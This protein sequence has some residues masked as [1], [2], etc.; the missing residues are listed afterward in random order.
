MQD[1]E[2]AIEDVSRKMAEAMA[3]P[4]SILTSKEMAQRLAEFS[5]AQARFDR[6]FTP[7]GLKQLFPRIDL[8]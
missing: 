5:L 7:S 8:S 6:I 4:N 1:I 3:I 2:L